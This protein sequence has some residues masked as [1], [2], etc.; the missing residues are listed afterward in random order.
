VLHVEDIAMGSG[1]AGPNYWGTATVL[2]YDEDLVAIE[3]VTVYGDWSGAT[4]E[5]QSDITLIDGR[6][7]FKSSKVSGG[8]T[9]TFTVTDVVKTGYTYDPGQNVETSDSITAP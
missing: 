6:I 9:F 4:V 3:G 7:T 8:G 5:S 2:I 1:Q